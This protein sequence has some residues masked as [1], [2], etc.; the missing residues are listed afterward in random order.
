ME[1]YSMLFYI[2]LS[3]TIALIIIKTFLFFSK[4]GYHRLKDWLHFS[5][6]N[7]YTSGNKKIERAKHIQNILTLVVLIFIIVDMGMLLLQHLTA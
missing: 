3:L 6:N 1:I 2:T 4:S 7:I 5:K